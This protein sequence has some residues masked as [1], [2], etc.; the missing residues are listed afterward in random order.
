MFGVLIG[1]S[2]VVAVFIYAIVGRVAYSLYEDN[3]I[4]DDDELNA[5]MA[6]VWPVTFPIIGGMILGGLLMEHK[7]DYIEKIISW[8]AVVLKPKPKIKD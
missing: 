3:S 2:V 1:L 5:L 8:L 7:F 6:I 4:A